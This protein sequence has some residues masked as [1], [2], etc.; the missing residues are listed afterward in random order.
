[1]GPAGAGRKG[2]LREHLILGK[3]IYVPVGCF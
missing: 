3:I 1:M 2:G